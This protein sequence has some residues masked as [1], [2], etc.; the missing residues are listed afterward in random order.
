[1]RVRIAASAPPM[2]IAG[3]T[4][5]ATVPEPETGS[6]PSV[7]AKNRI[8]MGPRAKLGKDNPKRLTTLSNRSS[9]RVRRRPA[10]AGWDRRVRSELEERRWRRRAKQREACTTCEARDS[11]AF[12]FAEG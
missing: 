6:N 4:R 5:C 11:A 7:I 10:F 2:V 12:D 1:M 8:R 9:Q 3:R